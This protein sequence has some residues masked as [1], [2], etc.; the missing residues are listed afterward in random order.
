VVDMCGDVSP[1]W[2]S[3]HMAAP[4]HVCA[5]KIQLSLAVGRADFS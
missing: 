2:A 5:V 4:G 1:S 3:S